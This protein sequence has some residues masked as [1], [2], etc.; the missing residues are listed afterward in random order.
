MNI[1]LGAG[2]EE[3][4]GLVQHMQACEVDITTIH[5]VGCT[6]LGQQQVEGVNVVQLA[7]R[8]MDE[9][10]ML[11]RRSS[12]VCIFT[13]ALVERKCAHGNSDRHKSIVVESSA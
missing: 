9:L 4:A 12:R 10:G 7:V 1:R 11:P 13:A 8:D 3:G 2:D 6:G 5:D